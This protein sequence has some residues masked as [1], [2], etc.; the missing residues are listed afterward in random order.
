M[1]AT[2]RIRDRSVFALLRRRGRRAASGPLTLRWVPLP[3]GDPPRVAYAVG[4]AV[5]SAVVRN[6]LRRQLRWS[7]ETVEAGLP[8]GAYLI[9]VSPSAVTMSARELR[10]HVAALVATVIEPGDTP[11]ETSP[12]AVEAV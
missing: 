3:G 7:L 1:T 4:K 12:A 11:T 2:W 6:K 5:G 9:R 8:S 10:T